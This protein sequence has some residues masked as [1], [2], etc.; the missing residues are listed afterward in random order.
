MLRLQVRWLSG[1]LERN[2]FV[3]KNIE[4]EIKIPLKTEKNVLFNQLE[5]LG[6]SRI[7]QIRECDTYFNSTFYDFRKKDEALRIRRCE[8]LQSGEIH[9]ELTYKGP[10]LDHIS[11]T[12]KEL[13]CKLESPEVLR[14][15]LETIGIN[16]LYEVDKTRIYYK[17]DAF[18]ACVDSVNK[19]GDFLELEVITEEENREKALADIIDILERLGYTMAETT[20][21]SYL[22]MLMERDLEN[23]SKDLCKSV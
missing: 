19:L 3:M 2:K 12:R 20:R 17:K 14:E 1:S 6:F 15:I 7:K 5:N 22:T 23:V 13:E 21:T 11:M 4:V 18:T 8:D 10:K 16:G 9:S